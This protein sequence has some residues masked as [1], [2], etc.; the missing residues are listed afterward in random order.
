VGEAPEIYEDFHR[1]YRPI[2]GRYYDFTASLAFRLRL[3]LAG[4]ADPR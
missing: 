3:H 2:S 1:Q 4:P